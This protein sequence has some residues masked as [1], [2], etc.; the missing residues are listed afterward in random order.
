MLLLSNFEF[1]K[2]TKTKQRK[3]VNLKHVK[4]IKLLHRPDL[5][6]IFLLL[7]SHLISDQAFRIIYSFIRMCILFKKRN[8]RR[9]RKM[10]RMNKVC[11]IHLII[12]TTCQLC[13]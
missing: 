12:V 13:M 11:F 6:Y 2:R 8:D 7:N 10:I 4:H 3:H 5:V 1:Q 9:I